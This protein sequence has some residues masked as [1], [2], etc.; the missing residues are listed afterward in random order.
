MRKLDEGVLFRKVLITSA[1]VSLFSLAVVGT[2]IILM[3]RLL[4]VQWII[5]GVVGA[6]IFG[7]A[8]SLYIIYC[9]LSIKKLRELEEDVVKLFNAAF[10]LPFK[11]SIVAFFFWLCGSMLLAIIFYFFFHFTLS[12]ALFSFLIGI[13]GGIFGPLIV[14]YL[15]KMEFSKELKSISND[16]KDYSIYKYAERFPFA[17]KKLFPLSLAFLLVFL[18]FLLIS[19]RLRDE[20]VFGTIVKIGRIEMQKGNAVI[21]VPFE[22]MEGAHG[23]SE[24]VSELAGKGKDFYIE[25]RTN[26]VMVFNKEDGRVRGF[27]YNSKELQGFASSEAWLLWLAFFVPIAIFSVILFLCYRDDKESFDKMLSLI[28]S[29]GYVLPTDDEWNSVFYELCKKREEE[30]NII[31]EREFER[32][33]AYERLRSIQGNLYNVHEKLSK[34]EEP[35]RRL[36][37]ALETL[38]KSLVS[39]RVVLEEG[40]LED[41]GDEGYTA[42]AGAGAHIDEVLDNLNK[43]VDEIEALIKNGKLSLETLTRF[44]E[45][46][47]SMGT[48]KKRAGDPIEVMDEIIRKLSLE[49]DEIVGIENKIDELKNYAMDSERGFISVID[50]IKKVKEGVKKVSEIVNVIKDVVEETNMLSLNAAIIAAQSGEKGKSFAVVAEEIKELADRTAMSTGEIKKI[51]EGLIS[52]VGNMEGKI[53]EATERINFF[54]KSLSEVINYVEGLSEQIGRIRDECFEF[55]PIIEGLVA[56]VRKVN[57][58]IDSLP[59]ELYQIK[60]KGIEVRDFDKFM[61]IISYTI[62]SLTKLKDVLKEGIEKAERIK[63]NREK[64]KEILD[65]IKSDV[66]NVVSETEAIFSIYED[67]ESLIKDVYESFK[68]L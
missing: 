34:L 65:R 29:E 52:N 33:K 8:Y 24:I 59:Q 12:Q 43:R 61:E 5:V 66:E 21:G 32:D 39:I 18:F 62:T 68:N 7:I 15:Y 47:S 20:S 37:N 57:A 6:I 58:M 60:E 2:C 67:A 44:K 53:A 13:I 35:R 42:L 26:N 11:L 63:R 10:I 1:G 50:S 22:I 45:I 56:E 27:V 14:Y 41:F 49:K 9:Y 55:A 16:L 36:G 17:F 28:S 51:V 38:R 64:T 54:G 4:P 25:P 23:V 40:K 3:V 31:V 46:F 30:R 48:E 19:I